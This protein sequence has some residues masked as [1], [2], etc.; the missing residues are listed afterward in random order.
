MGYSTKYVS[1]GVGAKGTSTSTVQVRGDLLVK[2][3]L[4]RSR[5]GLREPCTLVISPRAAEERACESW[6]L[7]HVMGEVVAY[8]VYVYEVRYRLDVVVS[9]P[10]CDIA[11]FLLYP[12]ASFEH[13]LF[14][15]YKGQ[16]SPGCLLTYLLLTLSLFLRTFRL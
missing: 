2:P 5:S 1:A 11:S 13:C 16:S 12:F 7:P 8:S 3:R 10:R 9:N 6:E 4:P 15:T 14:G